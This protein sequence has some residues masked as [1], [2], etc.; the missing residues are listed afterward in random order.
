MNSDDI[1]KE[2]MTQLSRSV[3]PG[4]GKSVAATIRRA[5]DHL[6]L[7]EDE[8]LPRHVVKN[9]DQWLPRR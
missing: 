1:I 6:G 4:R 3:S 7:D 2:L 5:C 8:F 9:K